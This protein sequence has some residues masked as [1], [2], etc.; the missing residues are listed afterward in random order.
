MRT[1]NAAWPPLR[2]RRRGP[3]QPPSADTGTAVTEAQ[4]EV[5]YALAADPRMPVADLAAR[6][7]VSPATAHRRLTR[8]L[9]AQ[10]V[11]RCELARSL[12]PWPVS[13][14]FFLR[15]PADKLDVTAQALSTL[16]E[17][18]AVMAT[19]GSSTRALPRGSPRSATS[20]G[21]NHN[22]PPACRTSRSPT[23]RS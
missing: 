17:V 12:T 22:W 8:L 18:R 11:L 16:R 15:C 6:L 10:P 13:A 20:T 19:V 5:A 2:A 23:A 3:G 4:H 21:W 1:P 7:G 9:A 14:T